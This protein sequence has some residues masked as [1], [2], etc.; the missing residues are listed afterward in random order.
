MVCSIID[1]V[2]CDTFNQYNDIYQLKYY[3]IKFVMEGDVDSFIIIFLHRI[4]LQ[5][6]RY[7]MRPAF[8]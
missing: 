7:Y 5:N 8:I 4:Q 2:H 1:W 3:R 6:Y